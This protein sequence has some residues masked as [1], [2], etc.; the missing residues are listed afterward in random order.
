NTPT[1][2][3]VKSGLCKQ[4]QKTIP[5]IPKSRADVHFTGEWTQTSTG[6]DFILADSE[7]HDRIILF[8]TKDNLRHLCGA[9]KLFC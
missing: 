5:T 8:G 7:T 1:F 4:R 3:S 6:D 2:Y 9:E